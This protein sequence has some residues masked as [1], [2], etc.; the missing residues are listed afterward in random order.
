MSRFN[1]TDEE[2]QAVHKSEHQ[3][4]QPRRTRGNAYIPLAAAQNFRCDKNDAQRNHRLN[5][6]LWD[7]DV[8]ECCQSKRDAVRDREGSNGL[9]QF[10][11]AVR[12]DDQREHEQEMV[13]VI[14]K[15]KKVVNL[16]LGV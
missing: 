3:H 7:V 14:V 13:N 1:P 4:H 15:S 12:D 5:W 9:D 8:A 6:S 11:P 2:Q 10:P 16:M